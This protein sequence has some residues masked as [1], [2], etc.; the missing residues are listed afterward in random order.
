M[1]KASAPVLFLVGLLA[2]AAV[3]G[4]TAGIVTLF[5]LPD[6]GGDT[7][8]ISG[9]DGESPSVLG[10]DQVEVTGVAVG[11]TVEGATLERVDTP[12]QVTTPGA[13]NGAGATLSGV[14]VD[15]AV[16]EIVWDAGRPFDLQG[17]ELGIVPR[18]VNLF[19]SPTA[20]TVGFPDG[21]AHQLVP[22]AYGL[23]TP[24]AVGRGGLAVPQDAVAFEA[25]DESTITFRGG[26]TTSVL[27][28]ALELEATGRVLLEGTLSVRRPDGSSPSAV[29][30]ELREGSFRVSAT[31]RPDGTGY[32][33]RVLL[34][35]EV[36]VT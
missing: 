24:V 23:Q 35:G 13:G 5:D 31:L 20:L 2:V 19:A 32:D 10:D 29:S 36:F 26:A 7:G 18:A 1:R 14:E 28:R 8:V 12:L 33:V 4:V 17:A 25:T 34:Q 21:L 6:D 15:G 3:A 11:V 27:P 16:T 9:G 22:G 30:V